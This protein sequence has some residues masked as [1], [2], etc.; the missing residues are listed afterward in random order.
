MPRVIRSMEGSG[1]NADFARIVLQEC[2]TV[3]AV[4]LSVHEKFAA[5]GT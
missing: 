5:P 3:L 4:H 2:E 1:H